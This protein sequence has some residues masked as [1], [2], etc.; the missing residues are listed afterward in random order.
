MF[1]RWQSTLAVTPP[2]TLAMKQKVP[3]FVLH[4]HFTKNNT[5][6]TLSKRVSKPLELPNVQPVAGEPVVFQ[7]H[8]IEQVRPKQ[9]VLFQTSAGQSGFTGKRKRSPEA[10]FAAT[11]K[12]LQKMSEP[13]FLNEPLEIVMHDFGPTRQVFQSVLF[14]REGTQVRPFVKRVTDLTKIKFGGDRSRNKPR[15]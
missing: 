4:C 8:L 9:E 13:G 2:P 7:Q 3:P 10:A 6:Y 11:T 15:K 12:L 14:G 5:K 1:R